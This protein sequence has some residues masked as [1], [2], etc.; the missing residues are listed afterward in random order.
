[1]TKFLSISV[2]LSIASAAAGAWCGSGPSSIPD[3]GTSAVSWDV[4]VDLPPDHLVVNLSAQLDIAHPW[5]GDLVVDLVSPEGL[6]VRLLDR[7]GMP[8]GGWIGP[9]GCGG[10]DMS[11]VFNDGGSEDAESTC[12]QFDVPVLSGVKRPLEPLSAFELSLASGLWRLEVR[13]ASPIDSGSL[14]SICLALTTSPDCNGNGQPD[15][16]DIAGGVSQDNDGDGIP[17]ECQCP[18]DLTGDAVVDVNDLLLLI[19]Q[20]GGS[21][22]G[23]LNGSGVVDADD[24]LMVLAAWGSCG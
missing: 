5:V 11:V 1:M 4:V 9:W 6:S 13:D 10:D 23:D 20:F 2:A 7:P 18:A 22:S 17:D 24:L 15:V 12:S 8:D 3:N 16:E 19:G 14:E 21:G